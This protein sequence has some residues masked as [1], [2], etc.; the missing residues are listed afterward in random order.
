[1]TM[2]RFAL[3]VIIVVGKMLVKIRLRTRPILLWYA[4]KHKSPLY[5]KIHPTGCNEIHYNLIFRFQIEFP[6]SW[7]KR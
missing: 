1:M 5:V 6:S 4:A 7:W 2:F 3:R